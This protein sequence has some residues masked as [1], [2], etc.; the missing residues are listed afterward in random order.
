MVGVMFKKTCYLLLLFQFSFLVHADL[1]E[2]LSQLP[3]SQQDRQKILQGE[4]VQTST[5]AT[6]D[7]E[8]AVL[9]AFIVKTTPD[10]FRKN[11]ISGSLINLPEAIITS[12]QLTDKTTLNDL[13]TLSFSGKDDDEIA[14]FLSAQAGDDLNLSANE[15]KQFRSLNPIEK[16]SGEAQKAVEKQLH[17]LFLERYHAYK[18]G[19]VKAIAPYQRKNGEKFFLGEY[20]KKTS[21][22]DLP[23]IEKEFPI[24]FHALNAYPHNKPA[25]L[26][27]SFFALKMNVQGSTIFS[28]MH[29]MILEEEGRF[30]M[31]VRQ[32]YASGSFNGEQDIGVAIPVK[33]GVLIIGL[34]RSSSDQVAGFGSGFKRSV[35]E[36]LFFHSLDHY[37][38]KIQ[39][40]RK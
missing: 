22:Q 36:S 4:L 23:I 10:V 29:R 12:H 37:F 6:E 1:N 17:K 16:G 33:D 31:M 38:E 40:L 27:E 26:D 2:L 19:G 28:L 9:L 25:Q 30:A 35:G 7:R 3:F 34:F 32:Y 15:I 21:T 20:F 11:F 8:L 5:T 18:S 24:Y 39:K 13:A 14:K